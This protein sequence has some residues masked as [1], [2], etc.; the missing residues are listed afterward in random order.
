MEHCVQKSKLESILERRKIFTHYKKEHPNKF[1]EFDQT[2]LFHLVKTCSCQGYSLDLFPTLVPT[3]YLLNSAWSWEWLILGTTSYP[4]QFSTIGQLFH[5]KWKKRDDL[6]NVL[7]WHF[8]DYKVVLQISFYLIF[9]ATLW[10]IQ[11]RNY[12]P[13]F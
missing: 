2:N 12:Y 7:T 1:L 10:S 8:I 11:W 5:W 4:T 3:P 9:I 6:S 13:Q